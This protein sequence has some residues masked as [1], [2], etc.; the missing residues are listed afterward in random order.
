MS[1]DRLTISRLRAASTCRARSGLA[2]VLRWLQIGSRRPT[3]TNVL[4]DRQGMLVD[5]V[6]R[7][8]GARLDLRIGRTGHA[9]AAV[10][11][12]RRMC[13]IAIGIGARGV[14]HVL[15]PCVVGV[16]RCGMTERQEECDHG[17]EAQ[18]RPR[19]ALTAGVPTPLLYALSP[20]HRLD[21]S[22]VPSACCRMQ[23]FALISIK[24]W[25][26]EQEQQ[27]VMLPRKPKRH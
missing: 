21:S 3:D 23:A 11:T 15:G 20:D 25:P 10:T 14:R 16:R 27:S 5:H 4:R 8:S 1:G 19:P 7:C 22:L 2:G 17:E 26:L 13:T 18:E 9:G 12:R 24:T 6:I